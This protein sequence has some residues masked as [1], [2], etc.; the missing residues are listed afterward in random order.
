MERNAYELRP[1]KGLKRVDGYG[2]TAYT[3]AG[4]IL[5]READNAWHI[6]VLTDSGPALVP[7]RYKRKQDIHRAIL[8]GGGVSPW[9]E[10]PRPRAYSEADLQRLLQGMKQLK[11]PGEIMPCMLRNCLPPITNRSALYMMQELHARGEFDGVRKTKNKRSGKIT[12]W[13]IRSFK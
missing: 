5:A 13:H 1:R 6:R 3:L 9:A 11:T 2:G 12:F 8:A 7:C 10:S 4:H